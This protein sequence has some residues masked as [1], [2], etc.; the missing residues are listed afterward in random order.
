MKHELRPAGDDDPIV[1][2]AEERAVWVYLGVVIL[3]SGAY[4]AV[5]IP[6]AISQPIEDVSWVAP[7]LWA[8]G[9][10]ILG[11]I[12]GSIVGSVSGAVGLAIRGISPAGQLEG[13]QRDKDIK[14]MGDRRAAWAAS[15]SMLVVLVLA[16]IGADPFWIGNTVF[17]AGTVGALLETITKIVAYR[18]GF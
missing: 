12:V 18:R 10:S 13:D 15:A 2:T 17:V 1:M 9:F 14:A 16:M 8:L 7:M 6:R 5:V 3:T 4:L 11:T